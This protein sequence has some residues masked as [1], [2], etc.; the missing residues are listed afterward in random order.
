MRSP[1]FTGISDGAMT[2]QTTLPLASSRRCS[3]Y[4]LVADTNLPA[5]CV[6]VETANELPDRPLVVV[7]RELLRRHGTRSK[8]GLCASIPT[9]VID[10]SMTG[11]LRMRLWRESANPR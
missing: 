3:V 5:A 10:P 1:G 2:S 6:A 8:H 9:Q 4:P 7:D 11:S